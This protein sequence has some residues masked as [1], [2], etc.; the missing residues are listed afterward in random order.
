M[1]KDIPHRSF[2][3]LRNKVYRDPDRS[4]QGAT[5]PNDR[6]HQPS[7]RKGMHPKPE[8]FFSDHIGPQFAQDTAT[9]EADH[10][11]APGLRKRV[12]ANHVG[13]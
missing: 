8:E 3:D 10:V 4:D 13:E 11:V 12:R 7:Y 9:P 1:S 5:Q 6:I 2:S